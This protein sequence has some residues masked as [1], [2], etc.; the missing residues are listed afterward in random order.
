MVM[1]EHID[2]ILDPKIFLYSLKACLK[3]KKK[4]EIVKL[5]VTHPI[6]CENM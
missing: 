1:I 5:H 4:I 2:F 3:K 6:K